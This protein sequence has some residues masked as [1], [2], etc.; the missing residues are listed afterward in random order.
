MLARHLWSV[1]DLGHGWTP[2]ACDAA[3]F[4]DQLFLVFTPELP[5]LKSAS[6]L[7]ERLLREAS[8]SGLRPGPPAL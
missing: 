2:T 4:A 3:R 1:L 8:A 6:R 5:A 7:L